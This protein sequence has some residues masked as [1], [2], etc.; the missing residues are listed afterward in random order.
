M[1]GDLT[2][3]ASAFVHK[4]SGRISTSTTISVSPTSSTTTAVLHAMMVMLCEVGVW[5]GLLLV[6]VLHVVRIRPACKLRLHSVN[7]LVEVEVLQRGDHS[8]W[9]KRGRERMSLEVFSFSE[10]SASYMMPICNELSNGGEE[11]GDMFV[12]VATIL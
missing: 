6:L 2:V 4:T 7:H 12:K 8:E 10:S 1:P 5:F 11:G 3:V 9:C